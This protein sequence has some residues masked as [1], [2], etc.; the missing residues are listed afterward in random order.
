MIDPHTLPQKNKN[1][2]TAN[3]KLFDTL[4]KRKPKDLDDRVHGFHEEAFEEINCINC[5]NC[6]KTTSPIFT[7]KDID[8]LSDVF[9]IRPSQFIEKY[10][11]MD[12][13]GHYVLYSSPCPFLDN[14][15][16]CLVYKDRPTACKEYPHTNRK[17]FYQILD[18][19][20]KN[21]EICPAVY[22]IVEKLKKIY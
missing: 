2:S 20:D 22:S 17:R 8:R 19:T 4:K 14:D 5:A 21:L 7:N 9:K 11:Y 16:Y 13:D 1:N 18:L 3:K 15:N 10:L 12:E 6:C